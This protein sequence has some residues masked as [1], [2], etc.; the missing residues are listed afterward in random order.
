MHVKIFDKTYL[1][2][3]T[4][5]S[6]CSLTDWLHALD[7]RQHSA[8]NDYLNLEFDV[9]RTYPLLMKARLG[10]RL[11]I[12][13]DLPADL[14]NFRMPSMPLVTLTENAVKHG[15]DPAL[16]GVSSIA[17]TRERRIDSN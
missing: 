5:P 11:K 17:I 7:C 4:T 1:L 14:A 12:G 3:P 2:A 6:S 10:A 9:V 8:G 16:I 13:V 15:V